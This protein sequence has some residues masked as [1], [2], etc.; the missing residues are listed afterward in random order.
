MKRPIKSA[1]L[2]AHLFVLVASIGACSKLEPAAS[3]EVARRF[4]I[5]LN[6]KDMETLA[7]LSA[8]PLWVRQ[9]EW[10]SAKDGAGFVLASANDSNLTDQENIKKYF[11]DPVKKISVER[12]TPDDASLALLHTELKGGEQ[13]WKGLSI[14]LFRRGMGDVEHIFVVGVDSKGKVAAVY[15]N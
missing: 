7:S 1:I 10:V 11:S 13:V 15:L 3:A 2:L 5:S 9:Q 8:T 12:E 6:S 14:Y 4:V